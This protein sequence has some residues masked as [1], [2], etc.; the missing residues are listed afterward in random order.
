MLVIANIFRAYLLVLTV[1][2]AVLSPSPY[3]FVAL[4]LLAVQIFLIYRGREVGW[5]LAGIIGTIIILPLV[6]EPATGKWLAIALVLP[7]IVLLD[8]HLRRYAAQVPVS[9]ES[10]YPESARR[11]PAPSFVALV[12]ALILLLAISLVFGALTLSLT[13]ALLAGYFA[14]VLACI[15]ITVPRFPVEG[16]SPLLRVVAGDSAR[17]TATLG[18]RAKLPLHLLWQP[19]QP[20]VHIDPL[21]LKIGKKERAEFDMFIVPPLAGPTSVEVQ[22]VTTDPWGLFQTIQPV[23]LAA[24]HVIPRARYAEWLARRYLEQ[25]AGAYT[26]TGVSSSRQPLKGGRRG[27]EYYDSRLYQPGDSLRDI[28]WKHTTK[29]Q[30]LIVKEHIE[31]RGQGVIIAA[32]LEAADADEVDKLIYTFITTALT[33]AKE[34]VPT[35]L[36][37]Y[38]HQYVLASTPLLDPREA[39]KQALRLAQQTTLY[40]APVRFLQPSDLNR[41]NRS[42]NQ[43]RGSTALPARR[44]LSILELERRGIETAARV[45]PATVSLTQ[46]T[47]LAHPPALIALVLPLV[48]DTEA[49]SATLTKLRQRGYATIRLQAEDRHK[50]GHQHLAASLSFA[51]N[52]LTGDSPPS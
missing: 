45:H 33:L 2:A 50:T 31:A 7:G 4:F 52:R 9:I 11:K 26:S 42:I 16:S 21:R 40:P 12:V 15:L 18:N 17:L 29:F 20:W 35:A 46:T 14:A 41:L 32:S 36:A 13:V 49:L 47:A 34:S 22:A 23:K 8:Q 27:V 5:N 38:N 43:L 44:L 39:L 25:T 48:S 19:G 24:L 51:P 10:R 1:G 6:L 3:S 30:E 28:D 37:A